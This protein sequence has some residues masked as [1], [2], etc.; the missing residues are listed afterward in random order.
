MRRER[1]ENG[2]EK[3]RLGESKRTK[4][5]MCNTMH[6]THEAA[7]VGSTQVVLY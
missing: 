2:G 7:M 4:L 1:T 6:E 5:G 3:L